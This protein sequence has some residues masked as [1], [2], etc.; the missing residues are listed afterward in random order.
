MKKWL[1]GVGL[2]VLAALAFVWFRAGSD[3]APVQV[4]VEPGPPQPRVTPQEAGIDPQAIEAAV[5]YAGERNTRALLI[6]HGG[7]VVFEKYW[8]E[9]TAD[10]PVRISGF[11]PTLAAMLVGTA[12]NDRVIRD[13]DA[14]VSALAKNLAADPRAE[15]SWRQLLAQ[16]DAETAADANTLARALEGALGGSYEQLVADRLWRMLG[17]GSFSMGRAEVN[18]ALQVRADCCFTARVADWMRVAELLAHDGVFEGNQFTPPGYVQMMFSPAR[19]DAPH[20]FFTRVDGQFAAHDVGWLE[21]EGKQRLWIVPSL[22]LTILRVGDEPPGS[23]VFDEAMIPDTIIRGT[24]GWQP[25]RA[26][27]GIDPKKF[28]PH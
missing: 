7:H 2:A 11:T 10:T 15:I 14:P 6:G 20:G 1:V 19:K 28:A 18:G 24:A 5:Q 25:A 13:L 4:A 27:E 26:T 9:T 3:P 23:L 21:A 17:A 8:G 22:R 12:M 16:Y